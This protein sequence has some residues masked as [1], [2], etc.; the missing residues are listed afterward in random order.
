MLDK[1]KRSNKFASLKLLSCNCII[2]TL[3]YGLTMEQFLIQVPSKVRYMWWKVRV[4][5][6]FL[7]T[8]LPP[9]S[10][11]PN[12]LS[13]QIHDFASITWIFLIHGLKKIS[14]PIH[15]RKIRELGV[16]RPQTQFTDFQ[17]TE[18]S[19]SQKT[20]IGRKHCM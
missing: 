11:P 13:L 16:V 2:C 8:V 3:F 15:W 10:R 14:L 18:N 20:W 17:F 6:K 5:Q 7:Y 9:N 19:W 1:C 12:S 4:H